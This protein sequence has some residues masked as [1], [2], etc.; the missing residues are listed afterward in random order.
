M[1][2]YKALQ[3]KESIHKRIRVN[4]AREGK[5]MVDYVE[6]LLDRDEANA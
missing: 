6:D 4:A 1:A 5:T 2:E 3:I